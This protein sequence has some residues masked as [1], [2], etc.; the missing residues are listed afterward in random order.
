[1]RKY[2][3]HAI[4]IIMII[5]ALLSPGTDPVSQLVLA[6]PLIILYEVSIIISKY[7]VKKLE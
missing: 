2:R 6:V 4:I 7:S 5:A 3:R 1:M